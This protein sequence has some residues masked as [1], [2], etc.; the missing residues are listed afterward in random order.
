MSF[1]FRN[2]KVIAGIVVLVVVVG[3]IVIVFS[4]FF[5]ASNYQDLA[6]DITFIQQSAAEI[7]A[8]E[9]AGDE[10]LATENA[11][12][13]SATFTNAVNDKIA[14]SIT[15]LDNL[16]L[17]KKDALYDYKSA[18]KE[19]ATEI[20]AARDQKSWESLFDE[21][22]PFSIN[23]T[24][25][26]AQQAFKA[27]IAEIENLK[28]FGDAAIM[29]ND[30]E[31]MRYISAKLLV[32]Q[33]WLKGIESS[34]QSF[35]KLAGFSVISND[36]TNSVI[37][38]VYAGF[39]PNHPKR[40]WPLVRRNV[41]SK[42]TCITDFVKTLDPVV[43]FAANAK[44]S[45]YK[46][47]P[48]SAR[49]WQ[50]AW[51]LAKPMIQGAGGQALPCFGC[52]TE[53]QKNEAKYPPSVQGFFDEC[54]QSGGSSGGGVKERLPTTESGYTCNYKSG[55]NV[56]WNF[57]TYSGG[58]YKGGNPGCPEQ[59]L[60]PKAVPAPAVENTPATTIPPK[61]TGE[62]GC[63]DKIKEQFRNADGY[64]KQAG[65]LMQQSEG[66]VNS[67]IPPEKGPN[68]CAT[69]KAQWQSSKAKFD[70]ASADYERAKA[71]YLN[72]CGALPK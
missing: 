64:L 71:D 18:V 35:F 2:P 56:C 19:W 3:A 49:E 59:N 61:P 4:N 42:G 29:K 6:K 10:L 54:T 7:F 28:E 33:H 1:L 20:L 37:A 12:V 30:K 66:I 72:K 58:R 65:S 25:D 62:T 14:N 44:S 38:R 24:N 23:L 13:G 36:V 21:P 32:Q 5:K 26:G 15:N 48:G 46:Y 43:K 60:V 55:G 39:F 41:C 45:A 40:T 9:S 51:K 50:D 67:C 69:L 11:T 17:S 57:L 53:G 47:G 22:R 34:N 16:N 52:V 63:S 70:S 8:A 31:T 27:S 68:Y